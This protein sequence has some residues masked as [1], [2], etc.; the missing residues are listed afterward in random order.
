MGEFDNFPFDISKIP[1]SNLDYSISR[2]VID[3]FYKRLNSLS[4]T[5]SILAASND[6]PITAESKLLLENPL[7]E[8][9]IMENKSD[10]IKGKTRTQG[11]SNAYNFQSGVEKGINIDEYLVQP[12]YP[13]L[14]PLQH[15]RGSPSAPSQ[16]TNKMN[17]F[18][19]LLHN[20]WPNLTLQE[21]I[22][23]L[24]STGFPVE[25]NENDHTTMMH[26]KND[27]SYRSSNSIFDPPPGLSKRCEMAPF[28]PTNDKYSTKL[29][30]QIPANPHVLPKSGAKSIPPFHPAALNAIPSGAYENFKTIP[31]SCHT[32]D[33]PFEENFHRFMTMPKIPSPPKTVDE[34][35]D[36]INHTRHSSPYN[37][38]TISTKPE[39]ECSTYSPHKLLPSVKLPPVSFASLTSNNEIAYMPNTVYEDVSPNAL[40]DYREEK[41]G[42]GSLSK[43]GMRFNSFAMPLGIK[44]EPFYPIYYPDGSFAPNSMKHTNKIEKPPTL[45]YTT[46]ISSFNSAQYTLIV[47]VPFATTRQDLLACFEHYGCIDMATVVCDSRYRYPHKEWTA[48]AGY[49]F[50]RFTKREHA[51]RVLDEQVFIK[52]R[53]CRIRATWAKKDSYAKQEKEN[54][55]KIPEDLISSKYPEFVCSLCSYL[56]Q[57][58]IV[59]PCGHMH[60]Y[61]CFTRW[62]NE[63]SDLF[64]IFNPETHNRH[65]CPRCR[66]M[67]SESELIRLNGEYIGPLS[68]VYRLLSNLEVQCPTHCGWKGQY[69]QFQKHID[70]HS[71]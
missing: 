29:T 57:D 12:S 11:Y 20:L 25:S 52:I 70:L 15:T 13:A 19:M 64:F 27:P 3:L 1:A 47:N 66:K 6:T 50:I 32:Y 71:F 45:T 21:I 58:P 2:D 5:S 34:L 23:L 36:L 26:E 39:S 40:M 55:L 65:K 67:F 61:E 69:S 49:A 33:I 30:S 43:A 68:V 16:E 4:N 22:Y 7:V 54:F 8:Q 9:G 60:C 63:N 51:Q 46:P 41:D 24:Q 56:I 37:G 35:P 14:Y 10:F 53:G 17:E 59:T 28:F 44:P 18:A 38:S 62:M 48:T 31:N 42:Q